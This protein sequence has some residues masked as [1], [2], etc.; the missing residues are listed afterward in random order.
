MR[1]QRKGKATRSKMGENPKNVQKFQ[2]LNN[3]PKYKSKRNDTL[4]KEG[5][6][7]LE[8]CCCTESFTTYTT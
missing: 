5:I 2:L 3:K 4:T 6:S 1:K 7:K 8:G